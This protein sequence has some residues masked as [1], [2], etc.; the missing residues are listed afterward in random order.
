MTMMADDEDTA[1]DA[2]GAV[3][4]G[5]LARTLGFALRRAQAA[6]SQDF[7]ARFV[8]EDIRPTQFAVLM[9]LKHNP[10]LRQSQ[11]SFALGI[12]RTNFVPLFDALERRGLAERRRVAGDRRAA[13]L[14]LTKPGAET[15]ERLE[16][17]SR[18][19]EARFVGRL[20]QANRAILLG[21]LAQVADRAFDTP[22]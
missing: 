8:G 16:A 14:F 3:D 22:D 18:A 19:H 10:G 9:L 1:A 7:L 5:P 12:K 15:L 4:P 13:A 6:V 11:V 2:Y 21:L 17:L 20:G